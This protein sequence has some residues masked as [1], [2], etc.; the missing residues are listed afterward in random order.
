[1]LRLFAIFQF[2]GI[3]SHH[4]RLADEHLGDSISLEGVWCNSKHGFKVAQIFFG[5]HVTLDFFHLKLDFWIKWLTLLSVL[6]VSLIWR[7]EKGIP[8]LLFPI[9]IVVLDESGT[10]CVKSCIELYLMF[11]LPEHLSPSSQREAVQRE[12]SSHCP[13]SEMENW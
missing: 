8:S 7:V 11:F 9:V 13:P 2:F 4:W 1:M 6:S 10:T 5:K 12:Q 3:Y